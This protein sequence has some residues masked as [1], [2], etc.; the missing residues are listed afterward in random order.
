[1]KPKATRLTGAQ[2]CEIIIEF[3]SAT[4]FKGIQALHRNVLDI[5]DQLLCSE[6]QTEAQQ[7]YDELRRSFEMFQQ[8][9]NK[10]ALNVKRKKFMHLQKITLMTCSNKKVCT[11]IFVKRIA[12]STRMRTS[13][14]VYL[15]KRLL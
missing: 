2:R 1:M 6:V 4:D 11:L 12:H 3:E 10:L 15:S 7:M 14:G 8:N 9:V 13:T 5:D